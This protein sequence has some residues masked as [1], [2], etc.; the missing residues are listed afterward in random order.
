MVR[1]GA[2]VV[3]TLVTSLAVRLKLIPKITRRIKLNFIGNFIL[4]PHALA[5]F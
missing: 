4:R 1:K 3:P 5:R 2:A